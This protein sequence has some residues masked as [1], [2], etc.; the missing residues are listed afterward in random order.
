M[1]I[2]VILSIA[3]LVGMLIAH[4]VAM[5]KN[6]TY[7]K[8]LGAALSIYAIGF[9]IMITTMLAGY[10]VAAALFFGV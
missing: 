8:D 2:W 9:V 1:N 5:I 10:V 6:E 4:V 7:R 3:W